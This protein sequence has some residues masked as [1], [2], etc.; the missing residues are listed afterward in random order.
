MNLRIFIFLL[1]GIAALTFAGCEKDHDHDHN[2]ITIRF[3]SPADGAVIAD[4]ANVNLHIEVEASEENHDI[5]IVLYPHG[6]PN[7]KIID[8]HVH[9]HEKLVTFQQGVDLSSY[10]SGQEFHLRVEACTDHDCEEKETAE[11]GFTLQ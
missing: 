8:S 7:T 10:P 6:D 11:I 5:D 3:I 2:E 4:A 9:E 1:G